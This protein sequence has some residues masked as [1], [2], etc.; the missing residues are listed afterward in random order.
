MS[1]EVFKNYGVIGYMAFQRWF[2]EQRVL[3]K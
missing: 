1:A 3:I 2:L